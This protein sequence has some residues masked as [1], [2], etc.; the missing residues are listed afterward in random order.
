M[1]CVRAIL[2]RYDEELACRK[3][4]LLPRRHS[5]RYS[6]HMPSLIGALCLITAPIAASAQDVGTRVSGTYRIAVCKSVPCTPGDTTNAVAW[7]RLT[8]FD[9]A[10]VLSSFPQSLL[11]VLHTRYL[12]S[13]ANACY[14]LLRRSP[15][16]QTYAGAMGAGTTRWD[17]ESG[18]DDISFTLYRSPDARHVV[19]ARI[20]RDSL[21]GT[22]ESWGAGEAEVPWSKDTIVAVRIGPADLR[23]CVDSDTSEKD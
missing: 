20:D 3:R 17:R 12:R 8:L 19:H 1:W 6:L 2:L 11:R 16:P 13:P 22:G 23:A 7:G 15:E 21:H 14:A 4:C 18:S 10:L 9:S 5:V